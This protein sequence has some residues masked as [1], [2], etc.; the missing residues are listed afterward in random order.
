VC[1][2][3][4]PGDGTITN[5]VLHFELSTVTVRA[6]SQGRQSVA[7]SLFQKSAVCTTVTTASRRSRPAASMT[8]T[9]GRIT[10]RSTRLCCGE[11]RPMSTTSSTGRAHSG[12]SHVGC[13][14]RHGVPCHHFDF[15]IGTGAP[16]GVP[17]RPAAAARRRRGTTADR[18]AAP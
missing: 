2:C 11:L 3:V 10:I 14:L 8:P 17:A 13:G 9:A 7:L 12:D 4:R 16:V 15:W 1:A 5:S 18:E 6:R